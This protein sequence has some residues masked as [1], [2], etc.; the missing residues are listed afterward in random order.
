MRF[1]DQAE[2]NFLPLASQ[3]LVLFPLKSVI[4]HK[5]I[6]N[7]VQPLGG[8][9]LEPT[10]VGIHMVYFRDGDE[11]VIAYLFLPI[12]LLTFNYANEPGLDR[13][14]G[15]SQAHPSAEAHRL[16]LRPEQ[17]FVVG[18][19]SHMGTPYRQGGPF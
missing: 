16:D 1:L 13:A 9:I 6:L 17:L 8:E 11:S 10:D 7:L 2:S 19:Q 3:Q 4:V 12:E 14:A 18:I 15:K 5:E